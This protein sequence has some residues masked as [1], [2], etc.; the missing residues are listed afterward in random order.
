MSIFLERIIFYGK[1]LSIVVHF[2][3]IILLYQ[4]VFEKIV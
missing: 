4:T 2:N 3:N 1:L